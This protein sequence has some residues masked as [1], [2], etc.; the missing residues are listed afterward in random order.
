MTDTRV[1]HFFD[2]I[3]IGAGAAGM[4]C[5]ITAAKRGRK[6]I[7][8]DHANKMGKKILLSGG[9]RCN[10]TNRF[11]TD[12][13]YVSMNKHFCKSA[14]KRYT[15][16]DFENLVQ[17]SGLAYH[18]KTLGQLFCDESSKDI[19]QLFKNLLDEN[20]IPIHLNT[21]VDIQKKDGVF[22]AKSETTHY[23]ATSLVIATGGLSFPTMGASPFGYKIAEQF[24]LNV[25]QVRA[26]LVP[27]TLHSKELA[28]FKDLPGVSLPVSVTSKLGQHFK[29]A[30]LFTHRGLSGPAILQI[31]NYW[32]PGESITINLLPELDA[33]EMLQQALAN[34]PNQSMKQLLT[35]HFPQRF[36]L[37]LCEHYLTAKLLK[38]Y[39]P[40]ELVTISKLLN[41]FEI[42]PNGTEGYRTAEVTLGGVDTDEI[43]SKTFESH[44]VPG[45]YFIGEVLDVTGHLGGFNFQWAWSSGYCA[46]LYV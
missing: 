40:S 7:I 17:S 34:D 38:Q 1:K 11:T 20:H 26:G 43:S 19:L 27:L 3:V 44:R 8:L 2:V 36:A 21:S 22:I 10:F 46:G 29:E 5:A 35:K 16:Q 41:N 9:G 37:V 4:M 30:M 24:G 6:V 25:T 28:I 33:F 45:L 31:S 13:N 39:T 15:A 18:E 32:H 12:K 14:L 23:S 42:K